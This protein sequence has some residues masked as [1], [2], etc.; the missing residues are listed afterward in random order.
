MWLRA[1]R[2]VRRSFVDRRRHQRFDIDGDLA[3]TLTSTHLLRIANVGRHGALVQTF[4]PLPQHSVYDARLV[5]ANEECDV[6]FRV[7]HVRRAAPGGAPY[8]MG[9]EFLELSPRAVARIDALLAA[10]EGDEALKT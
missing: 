9:V 1:G 7:L 2:P 10:G 3:A 4:A 5:I 8:L 6:R